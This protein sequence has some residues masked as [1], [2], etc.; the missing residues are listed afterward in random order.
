MS[1]YITPDEFQ[2]LTGRTPGNDTEMLIRQASEQIDTLTFQRIKK[3]RF[4]N[5]TALQQ[6]LIRIV[7]AGQTAF[8]LDFGDALDSPLNSY[9]I[10]GVSMS[11]DKSALVTCSG[12]TMQSRLYQMLLQT[13]L[14][15]PVLR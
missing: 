13:N 14:C 10:A 11:W 3:I 1:A 6:E 5:L 2:E 9:S 12:I 4:E 8:L 15:N 7:T